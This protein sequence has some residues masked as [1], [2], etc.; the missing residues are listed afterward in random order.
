MTNPAQIS[1]PEPVAQGLACAIDRDAQLVVRLRAGDEA[2]YAEIVRRYHGSLVRVASAH[3]RSVAVA[4]EIA[5]DTWLAVLNG[6]ARFEG[7]SSFRTWLFTIAANL[8]KTRGAREARSVPFSAL[9]RVDGDNEQPVEADRF[10]AD[11]HWAAPPVD[12]RDPE[13]RLHD[14]E[15]LAQIERAIAQLPEAQRTVI[16]LR[17]VRG[18][19]SSEVCELLGITDG[20]QRVLLHRARAKV[21]RALDAVLSAA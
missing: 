14:S 13:A 16:T 6:L 3:V 21:R 8:A 19:D 18:L 5:Q 9:G 20:N 12:W 10:L 15:T 1:D 11:G 2:A 7:R 17:D 4:E